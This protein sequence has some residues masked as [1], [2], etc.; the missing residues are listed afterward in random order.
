[1]PID[2]TCQNQSPSSNF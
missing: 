1:M 2:K